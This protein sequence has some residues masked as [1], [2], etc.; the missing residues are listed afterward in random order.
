MKPIKVTSKAIRN[1]GYDEAAQAMEVEFHNGYR[2]RLEG[3]RKSHYSAFVNADS[4]GDHWNQNF[5]GE[6]KITRLQPNPNS[7]SEDEEPTA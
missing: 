1:V 2:Y 5:K 3:V 4:I 6:Y 7:K